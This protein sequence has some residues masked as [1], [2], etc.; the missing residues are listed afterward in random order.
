MSLKYT[1]IKVNTIKYYIY[2]FV[3][4]YIPPR[5]TVLYVLPLSIFI[6]GPLV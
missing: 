2:K 5:K 6:G 3:L 4:T 1:T